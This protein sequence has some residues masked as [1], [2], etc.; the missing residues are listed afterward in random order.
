MPKRYATLGIVVKRL[1]I[2]GH[3]VVWINNNG[4]RHQA[5]NIFMYP[6]AAGMMLFYNILKGENPKAIE[7]APD[8][9]GTV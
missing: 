9:Q 2:E 6:T 5:Y 4:E 7:G 3:S 8:E 1:W